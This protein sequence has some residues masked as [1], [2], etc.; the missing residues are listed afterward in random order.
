MGLNLIM[1]ALLCSILLSV[2]KL[3]SEKAEIE[4]FDE[5]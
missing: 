3:C 2:L 1:E 5:K 4:F